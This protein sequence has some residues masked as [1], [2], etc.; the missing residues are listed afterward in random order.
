MIDCLGCASENGRV[1]QRCDA[2]T[3]WVAIQCF[4][5]N[6]GLADE[7]PCLHVRELG[8]CCDSRYLLLV[9]FHVVRSSSV[10][11]FEMSSM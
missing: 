6:R 1:V 5:S 3:T 4:E 10:C 11:P 8:D 2:A 9:H 7:L